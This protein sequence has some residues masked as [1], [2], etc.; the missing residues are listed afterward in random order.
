ME[1]QKIKMATWPPSCDDSIKVMIIY[2]VCKY[3][4]I[5]IIYTC[6]YR[7]HAPI[8][9]FDNYYI[10]L[11]FNT[12]VYKDNTD[13]HT[14]THKYIYTYIYIYIYIYIYTQP[15]IIIEKNFVENIKL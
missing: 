15:F 5:Y 2:T 3:T 14:H 13:T 7:E 9:V 1:K 4:Y 6:V 11:F 8:K 12:N 10:L